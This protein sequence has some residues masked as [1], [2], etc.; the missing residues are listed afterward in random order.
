LGLQLP[1]ILGRVETTCAECGT[2]LVRVV[3]APFDI[4]VCPMDLRFDDYN[5]D[6][7]R[8]SLSLTRGPIADSEMIGYI[9][10]FWLTGRQPQ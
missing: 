6:E 9:N 2:T 3:Q 5:K 8:D 7:W 1:P 10:R 4:I